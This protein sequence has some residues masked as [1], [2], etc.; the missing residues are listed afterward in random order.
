MAATDADER[1]SLLEMD[2]P[3]TTTPAAKA[4]PVASKPTPTVSPLQEGRTALLAAP[5]LTAL[6]SVA[7]TIATKFPAADHPLR[8]ELRPLYRALVVTFLWIRLWGSL[9]RAVRE[10]PA[11][12]Q[13]APTRETLPTTE[14]HRA[15]YRKYA[16]EWRAFIPHT[17]RA[18]RPGDRVLLGRKDGSRLTSAYV[19]RLINTSYFGGTLAEFTDELPAVAVVESTPVAESTPAAESAQEPT[20][21]STGSLADALSAISGESTSN[22]AVAALGSMAGGQLAGVGFTTAQGYVDALAHGVKRATADS[23]LATLATRYQYTTAQLAAL[24]V[25]II[26]ET[27]LPVG[28][29]IAHTFEGPSVFDEARAKRHEAAQALRKTRDA[30]AVAFA[31]TFTTT[32]ADV[33]AWWEIGWDGHGS[34]TRG[35]LLAAVG[36][37]PEPK[38]PETQL[39]RTMDSLR[40]THD[41]ALVQ[42]PAGIRRRWQIGRGAQHTAFVGSEYGRVLAIVDLLPDGTLR[43]EGDAGISAE[44]RAEYERLT[45]DEVLRPGDVT[46]WLGQILRYQYGARRS[47]HNF[48]VPPA[49]RDEARELCTKL[50]SVW[51]RG[52]WVYGRMNADGTAEVGKFVTDVASILGALLVAASDEIAAA[53]QLWQATVDAA[54]KKGEKVGARAAANAL[55]RHDGERPAD[56]LSARIDGLRILGDSALAPLRARVAALRASIIAAVD[57]AADGTAL[58]A[59][60]LELK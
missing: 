14:P 6:D 13:I 25:T 54:A 58:R 22:A 48:L 4:A 11:L 17:G 24:T 49:R 18:I 43:W 36:R 50:S 7:H 39:G 32:A 55:T 47:A 26:P 2:L 40:R 27:V 53:E 59:A 20:T 16:G 51:A 3:S 29:G 35:E 37:A 15:N 19:G 38:V 8:V 12:V 60:M 44:V 30:A 31:Q 28:D 41:C 42:P 9:S 45:A 52:S 56:G 23:Y 57:E 5:S 10:R 1:F 34:I 46:S 33:D 21:S